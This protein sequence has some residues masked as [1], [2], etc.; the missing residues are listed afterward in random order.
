MLGLTQEQRLKI[1]P[2]LDEKFQ[3]RKAI[4]QDG[5]LT[6]D[7]RRAKMTA[8]RDA[9]HGKIATLLTPEQRVKAD[10]L[11]KNAME[12]K[13]ACLGMKRGHASQRP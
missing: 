6:R 13:A 5:N 3:E 11:R 4:W 2:I 8:L 12:R 7:Q 9:C 10:E 1:L